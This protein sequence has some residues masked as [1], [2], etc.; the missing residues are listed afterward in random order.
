MDSLFDAGE[1]SIQV[2]AAQIAA[3]RNHCPN[4]LRVRDVFQGIRVEDDEVRELAHLYGSKVCL[5]TKVTSRVDRGRLQSFHRSESRADEKFEFFMQAVSGENERVG[6][7]GSGH[8]WNARP[9]HLSGEGDFRCKKISARLGIRGT[10]LF[11]PSF[12]ECCGKEL[13]VGVGYWW[14]LARI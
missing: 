2:G 5:S 14:R 8:E 4:L 12:A 11:A 3:V 10:L 6:A 1:Q 7:V 13:P 9:M